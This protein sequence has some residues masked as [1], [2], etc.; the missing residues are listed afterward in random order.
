[1][2]SS[3]RLALFNAYLPSKK[4]EPRRARLIEEVYREIAT[5]EPL[6][7]GRYYL[8][9]EIGGSVIGDGSDFST[10]TIKYVFEKPWKKIDWINHITK[11][12]VL[13]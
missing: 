2:V 8:Q 12:I 6:P 11:H 7:D 9:L 5:D 10:P 4:H 1:M 13:T 3:G